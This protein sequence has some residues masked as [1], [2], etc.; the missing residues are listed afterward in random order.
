MK[1]TLFL[2]VLLVSNGFT[3]YFT[4]KN[5]GQRFVTYL[6]RENEETGHPPRGAPLPPPLVD[7][8]T[9]TCAGPNGKFSWN[10]DGSCGFLNSN[11]LGECSRYSFS[12]CDSGR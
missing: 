8:R 12:S 9:I 6:C 1:T 3:Y 11:V 10:E 2:V 4:A 7:V 5:R